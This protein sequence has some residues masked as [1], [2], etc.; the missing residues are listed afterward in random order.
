M[1]KRPP[2][3][4]SNSKRNDRTFS[5]NYFR[6]PVP[7][8][9]ATSP[10]P[11]VNQQPPPQ[12]YQQPQQPQQQQQQYQQQQHQYPGRSFMSPTVES[13]RTQSQSP[14]SFAGYQ[15]QSRSRSPYVIYD[16]EENAGPSTAEIIAN[17]SQDYVDEK[18]AEYQ[19]TIL[20]LQGELYALRF[21]D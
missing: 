3:Q 18:L 12:H 8:N 10:L 7:W 2:D 17:Q 9:S 21:S 16:E 1:A 5:P 20:Q 14:A 19:L 4:F 11:S 15:Q 6:S 13:I